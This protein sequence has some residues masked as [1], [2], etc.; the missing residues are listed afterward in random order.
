M[1]ELRLIF[2]TIVQAQLLV[3]VVKSFL[4]QRTNCCPQLNHQRQW[5]HPHLLRKKADNDD[6]NNDDN[7]DDNDDKYNNYSEQEEYEFMKDLS[8]A[9]QKLGT[10]IGY[11]CTE[12][13]ED[14]AENAQNAFLEAMKA[15][16]TDFETSKKE[17]GVEKAIDLIKDG[18]DM[19]DRLSDLGDEELDDS[20]EFE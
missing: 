1:K 13:A 12:E 16:S 9:K 7:D 10:P 18:W 8:S 3:T 20:G 5:N 11:E 14:A 6:D 4:I 15:V 2:A 19:D 17:V